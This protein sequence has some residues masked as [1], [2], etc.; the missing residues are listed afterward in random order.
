MKNYRI[1]AVCSIYVSFFF[2]FM[3]RHLYNL[4][5]PS[6]TKLQS[7]DF[8]LWMQFTPFMLKIAILM[9]LVIGVGILI[10]S[11]LKKN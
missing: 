1:F 6:I 2:L 5:Q 4:E 7:S 11:F 10:R 9:P 8:T 3:S